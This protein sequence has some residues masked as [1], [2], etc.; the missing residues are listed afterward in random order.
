[1]LEGQIIDITVDRMFDVYG[2]KQSSPI[3]W[4]AFVRRNE[5]TWFA[6]NGSQQLDIQKQSDEILSFNLTILN[7]GGKQQPFTIENVPNWLTVSE[8]SGSLAPNSSLSIAFE[9]DPDLNTGNYSLDLY[10]D[11]DFNFDEKSKEQLQEC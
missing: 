3:T 4:S 9:I 6:D 2:N 11:T 8:L 7:S 10:L 1:M 5:V